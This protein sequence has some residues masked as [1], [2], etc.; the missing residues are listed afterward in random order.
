MAGRARACSA[1]VS[2]LA[3][4]FE[5]RAVCPRCRRAQSVCWCRFVTPIPTRTKVV[6]LQ[7]PRERDMAIGTARMASLSLPGSEL[8]V[9][10]RWDDSEVLARITAD[11]DRPAALLFPGPGSIDVI[12]EPPRDPVTLVVVDGTW[13]QAKQ[14]V[15][16]NPRLAALPRYSFEP[17]A[18]SDYRIR[19]EPRDQYVSTI[20][21]LVHVLGAIEG[22]RERFLPMLVPFRA[23]VDTQI[24]CIER[25]RVRR[26]KLSRRS[27]ERR[28]H[29]P[30]VLLERAQDLVCLAAEAN[31]WPHGS[32]QRAP[33]SLGE[34]VHLVASR[35]A[36]GEEIDVVVAPRGAIAPNTPTNLGL[37]PT[38]LTGGVAL[39]ELVARWHGFL[40]P[41]DI[42]C[43]W[44][45]YAPKLV[46][47]V[48][49]RMGE[50]HVDLRAVSAALDSRRPGG[51]EEHAARV[52]LVGAPA[53]ARGRAGQ[54]VRLLEAILR[55]LAAQ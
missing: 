41:G 21:A 55:R 18:P 23:M 40:R 25:L 42:T 11:R 27:D 48:G 53:F 6:I 2:G 7:H 20:E 28:P 13:S 46:R 12:R 8:H 44:G 24:A 47:E 29:V 15:R 14:L 9:G 5:P 30:A 32:P 1:A 22:D 16:D 52:G 50:M 31:A 3:P 4:A 19:R 43:A 49:G 26:M 35:P 36:S 37:D 39:E 34:I 54:R 45:S 33:G 10:M 17:P 51:L 38:L